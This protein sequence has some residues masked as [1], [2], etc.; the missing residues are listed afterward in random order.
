MTGIANSTREHNCRNEKPRSFT[1]A[2]TLFFDVDDRTV[3]D[4]IPVVEAAVAGQTL[5]Q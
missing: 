3:Y 1:S 4:E 2:R 5:A